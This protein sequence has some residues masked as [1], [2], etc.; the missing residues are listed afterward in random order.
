MLPPGLTLGIKLL[1]EFH[2]SKVGGHSRVLRTHNCLAQ[3]FY[4]EAMKTDVRRYVA[5]CD[6]CQ[7][8]KSEACSSAGQ[9]QPLPIPSLVWEEVSLD[10]V[11][12]LPP[13][14]GKTTIM[15]DVQI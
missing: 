15:V 8:N 6:T 5:A 1:E 13:S 3:L 11:D 9:L 12:D 7:R 10:F 14:S 2:N 4:W